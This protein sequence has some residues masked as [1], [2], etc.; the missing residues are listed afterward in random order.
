MHDRISTVILVVAGITSV[1]WQ[2]GAIALFLG[3]GLAI[4]GLIQPPSIASHWSKMALQTGVVILG[5]SLP[6]SE[7][8]RLTSD[9]LS[10]IH[11]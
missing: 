9:N 1:V 3:A 8:I 4:S 11:I 10:L 7:I 2:Q 5:L 6:F